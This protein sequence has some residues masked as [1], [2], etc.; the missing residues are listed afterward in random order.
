ML[1]MKATKLFLFLW[2]LPISRNL[3]KFNCGKQYNQLE[4]IEIQIGRWAIQFLP[5]TGTL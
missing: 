2:I 5:E 3:K 1:G 4:L